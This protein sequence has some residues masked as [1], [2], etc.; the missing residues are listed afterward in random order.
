MSAQKIYSEIFSIVNWEYKIEV[1]TGHSFGG[2]SWGRRPIVARFLFLLIYN[3][4]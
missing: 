2:N 4:Y 1:G 3:T